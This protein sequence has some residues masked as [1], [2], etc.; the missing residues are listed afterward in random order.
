VKRTVK[1]THEKKVFG[2]QLLHRFILNPKHA[3]VKL[4]KFA[5]EFN[6]GKGFHEK[7]LRNWSK[8]IGADIN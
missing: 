1:E 7:V 8:E 3:K 6:E 4:K 2:E 5:H